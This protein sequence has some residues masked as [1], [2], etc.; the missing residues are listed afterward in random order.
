LLLC[1]TGRAVA[2]PVPPADDFHFLSGGLHMNSTSLNR[3]YHMLV[4]AFYI[5]LIWSLHTV[6]AEEPLA[7]PLE[8]TPQVR[9][10]EEFQSVQ[11]ERWSGK[12]NLGNGSSGHEI[13]TTGAEVDIGYTWACSGKTIVT[14]C[15]NHLIKRDILTGRFEKQDVLTLKYLLGRIIGNEQTGYIVTYD[16]YTSHQ[17]DDYE[18]ASEK[19]PAPGSITGYAHK[20]KNDGNSILYIKNFAEGVKHELIGHRT[21]PMFLQMSPDGK[22]LLSASSDETVRLWSLETGK[23]LASYAVPR[24][25]VNGPTIVRYCFSPDGKHYAINYQGRILYVNSENAKEVYAWDNVTGTT[26][27]TARVCFMN[28]GKSILLYNIIPD[29]E[30]NEK[31]YG[32]IRQ[33]MIADGK[34][35]EHKSEPVNVEKDAD[36]SVQQISADLSYRS[37][38]YL[39]RAEMYLL[40]G[41]EFRNHNFKMLFHKNSDEYGF[42]E[43]E[44][45]LLGNYAFVRGDNVESDKL[46]TW[47]KQQVIELPK[48]LNRYDTDYEYKG[49]KQKPYSTESMNF[50][51]DGKYMISI[52]RHIEEGNAQI[53]V[54][55][56]PKYDAILK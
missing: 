38:V 36:K 31:P 51:P 9:S 48:P 24:G 37:I 10:V 49:F 16:Q 21:S 56:A 15:G 35:I 17:F 34:I 2:Q 26:G 6:L 47:N 4:L 45:N 55:D 22:R 54:W 25:H 39:P 1:N 19:V 7:K 33:L 46:Y 28:D 42:A 3:F 11:R 43:H 52:Q 32:L 5:L 8:P 20:T 41:Y 12:I 23:E 29:L 40:N 13:L 44:I 30:E 53:K 18:A 27:G 50:S 14:L